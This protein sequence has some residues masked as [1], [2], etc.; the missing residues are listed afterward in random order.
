MSEVR[1]T[2]HNKQL[3]FKLS[4]KNCISIP[5]KHFQIACPEMQRK[6][7]F[8]AL[9]TK[10]GM[11]AKLNNTSTQR[12]TTDWDFAICSDDLVQLFSALLFYFQSQLTINLGRF[13]L[14]IIAGINFPL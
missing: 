6:A 11:K 1:E 12:W 10:R 8:P 3:K 2:A 14:C 9:N 13:S 5:F 7:R 4:I